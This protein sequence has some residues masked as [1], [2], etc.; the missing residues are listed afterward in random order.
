MDMQ[1]KLKRLL[2]LHN[3]KAVCAETGISYLA[4]HS[5]MKGRSEM[6]ISTAARL[7]RVLRVDLGWLVDPGRTEWPPPAWQPVDGKDKAMAA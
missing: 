7:C 6:K 2:R 5:A 4:L 1:Q 3:L